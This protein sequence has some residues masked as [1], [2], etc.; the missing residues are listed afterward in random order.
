MPD[1]IEGQPDPSQTAEPQSQEQAP[2]EDQSRFD[3]RIAQLTAA[4]RQAEGRS[5][6][7]ENQLA[8]VT[9]RL[10]ELESAR[11]QEI[12]AS[13]PFSTPSTPAAGPDIGAI[14]K[15]TVAEAVAPFQQEQERTALYTQ[16]QTS[17]DEAAEFLPDV[18]D[19]NTPAGKLFAQIY[20]SNPELQRMP[21][22]PALVVNAVAGIIGAAPKNGK[23]LEERKVAT[24]SPQPGSPTQYIEDDATSVAQAKS[25]LL[26]QLTSHFREGVSDEEFAAYMGLKMGKAKPSQ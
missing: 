22:G 17:F 16:Q 25:K 26:N 10:A 6:E 23:A 24:S 18:R 2:E 7:L 14:I 21:T 13:D 11:P 20:D 1:P 4:R 19:T 9:S 8:Q 3:R 5:G 15:K 12:P